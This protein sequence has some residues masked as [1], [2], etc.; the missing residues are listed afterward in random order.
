MICNDLFFFFLN[1]LIFKDFHVFFAIEKCVCVTK[2]HNWCRKLL[3]QWNEKLSKIVSGCDESFD[4]LRDDLKLKWS[5]QLI[6]TSQQQF[7]RHN[8]PGTTS[9]VVTLSPY[10]LPYDETIGDCCRCSFRYF[11]CMTTTKRE[12]II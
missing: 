11:K 5:R 9:N 7:S 1:F 4:E 8:Q 10:S 2:L 12:I 3:I 6:S